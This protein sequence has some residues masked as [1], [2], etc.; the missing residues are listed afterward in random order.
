MSKMLVIRT[1]GE[2]EMID[3]TDWTD[4]RKAVGGGFEGVDLKEATMYVND[5]GKCMSLPGNII[6]TQL[7]HKEYGPMDVIVG[8]VAIVGNLSPTGEYDGDDYD[9]PQWVIDFARTVS[10]GFKPRISVAFG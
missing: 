7:F 1:T 10:E 2:V 4:I 6:A 9:P 3:K 8:D 5:E